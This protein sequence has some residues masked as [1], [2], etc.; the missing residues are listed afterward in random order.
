M[1]QFTGGGEDRPPRLFEVDTGR[2]PPAAGWL[3][4]L[5]AGRD[6]P[7]GGRALTQLKRRR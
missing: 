3:A 6:A 4:S 7:R 5:L 2:R 1:N